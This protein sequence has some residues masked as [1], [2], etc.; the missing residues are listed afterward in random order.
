MTR[1]L[2]MIIGISPFLMLVGCASEL[3]RHCRTAAGTQDM[4]C[5]DHRQTP[6]PDL[7][8]VCEKSGSS[9]IRCYYIERRDIDKLLPQRPIH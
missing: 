2:R 3:T 1:I 6:N 5:A 7:I 8:R 4:R 9:I